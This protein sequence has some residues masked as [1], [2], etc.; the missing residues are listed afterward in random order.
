MAR[1]S[2]VPIATEQRSAVVAE[3]ACHVVQL[4]PRD[5]GVAP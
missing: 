3:A 4:A 5:R 1:L 2:V